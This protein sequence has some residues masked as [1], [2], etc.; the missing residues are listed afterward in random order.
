MTID[1]EQALK[2][3]QAF[4]LE[5]DQSDEMIQLK[6]AHTYRV[7]SYCD[8]IAV[9]LG[10]SKDE[11]DCVWLSGLLH[12]VGRFEQIRKY[13]TFDDADSIDHAKQSE[14]FIFGQGNII[15]YIGEQN[16]IQ[17]EHELMAI[18]DAILFHSIYELPKSIQGQTLLFCNILRD[19]DKLDILH[20]IFSL[21]NGVDFSKKEKTFENEII[22]ETVMQDIR[23]RKAVLRSHRKYPYDFYVAHIALLFELIYPISYEILERDVDIEKIFQVDV[24]NEDTIQKLNEIKE[25]ILAHE[26]QKMKQ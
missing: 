14:H 3:F 18:K 22:S 1:R 6:I 20:S 8:E 17:M 4:V 12:D 25:I 24:T 10:L 21:P 19:A 26:L 5:Y 16:Y 2:A 13:H 15:S 9:N 7:C 11:K 23:Q